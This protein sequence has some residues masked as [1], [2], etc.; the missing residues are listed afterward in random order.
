MLR[1]RRRPAEP[2]THLRARSRGAVVVEFALVAPLLFL[3]LFGIVELGSA[4]N[5]Y[6]SVRQGVR[7]A[8]RSAVVDRVPDCAPGSD[9]TDDLIC[10]VEDRIGLGGDTR[11]RIEVTPPD[12]AVPTDR[13]AVQV[14]VQRP[15]RSVTGAVTPWLAG[16]VVATEVTMR[17]ERGLA[18][19]FV[20]RA[21][22]PITG[23]WDC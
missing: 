15:L 16:R 20:D 7:D 18:P 19:V 4:F 6:Q 21:E 14:C 9:P 10:H 11:V 5:D 2:P 22:A 3:L 8:A 23:T 13:G 12:P 17:V 1:G